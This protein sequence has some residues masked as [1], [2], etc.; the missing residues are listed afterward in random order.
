MPPFFVVILVCGSFFH[1][2]AN[3]DLIHI[4]KLFP[5]HISL[6]TY[7]FQMGEALFGLVEL[8]RF[9]KNRDNDVPVTLFCGNKDEI[10][11]YLRKQ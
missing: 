3:S 9:G 11:L 10:E 1:V 5:T 8:I 6:L 4:A 2:F 7:V